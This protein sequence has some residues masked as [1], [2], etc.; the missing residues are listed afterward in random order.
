MRIEHIAIWTSDLEAMKGFYTKYFHGEANQKYMNPQKKFASYFI[1]Y[2][3]GARLELMSKEGI[4]DNKNEA[5]TQ[6]KG[7]THFAFDVG[8]QA[9]VDSLTKKI[10]LAGYAVL[11]GPRRTGDGYYESTVL[12]PEGNRVEIACSL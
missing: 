11:D 4:P 2:Q 8:D 1:S 10:R 3:S 6:Y 5:E 9:E 7:L 12:D